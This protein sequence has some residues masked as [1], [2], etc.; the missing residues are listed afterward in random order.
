MSIVP[1]LLIP[2]STL[3]FRE[4]ISRVEIAGAFLA[5]AGVAVLAS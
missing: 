1:V 4:R 2:V 3:A 5:V